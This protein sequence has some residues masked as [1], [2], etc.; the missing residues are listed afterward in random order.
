MKSQ[1]FQITN[2]TNMFGLISNNPYGAVP[3]ISHLCYLWHKWHK[4]NNGLYHSQ[5]STKCIRSQ[6][7]LYKGKRLKDINLCY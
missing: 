4:L 3:D 7:C 2:D 5:S 6:S 1:G